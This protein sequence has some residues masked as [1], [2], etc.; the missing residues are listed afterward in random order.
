M[1][2]APLFVCLSLASA[3]GYSLTLTP[4]HAELESC[5][6]LR[7]DTER[8]ACYDHAVRAFLTAHQRAEE[9]RKRTETAIT[10][11]VGRF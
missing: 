8:L 6:A 5:L 10:T 11:Q 7:A 2:S 9:S 1:K 4:A 3:A